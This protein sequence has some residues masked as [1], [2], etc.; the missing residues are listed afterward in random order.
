[1]NSRD[2]TGRLVRRLESG[3]RAVGRN[4][5]RWDGT[6]AHGRTVPAGVYFIRLSSGGRVSTGRVTLVR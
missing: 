3:P 4:A 1:M 6:D 2:I 5:V